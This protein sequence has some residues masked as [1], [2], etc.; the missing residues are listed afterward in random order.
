M[1]AHPVLSSHQLVKERNIKHRGFFPP[2]LIL[3]N[4]PAKAPFPALPSFPTTFVFSQI[5]I[6]FFMTVLLSFRWFDGIIRA[7]AACDL[8]KWERG[9]RGD[10][11]KWKW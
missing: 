9:M 7:V 5:H 10:L 1:P 3:L 4:L 8:V 11:E 6:T 2:F